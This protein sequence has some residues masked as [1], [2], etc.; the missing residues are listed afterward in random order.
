MSRFTWVCGAC[1]RTAKNKLD[2]RDVSCAVNAFEC[3]TESVVYDESGFVI[4]AEAKKEKKEK[5]NGK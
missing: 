2:F 3:L 4:I 1:G 5:S